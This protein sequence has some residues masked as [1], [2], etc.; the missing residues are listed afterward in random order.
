MEGVVALPELPVLPV[1]PVFDDPEFPELEDEED[2]DDPE[3]VPPVEPPDD[4]E[5]APPVPFA[6]LVEPGCCWATTAP[7]RAAA[8]IA[9]ST[10]A[11]VARRSQA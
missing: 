1:E 8:P 11:R 9:P 5:L 6:V 2:P 7:I 4:P 10:S 3:L